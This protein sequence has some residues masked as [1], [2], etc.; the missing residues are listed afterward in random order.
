MNPTNMREQVSKLAP[1]N[2][3]AAAKLARKISDSWF[4]CQSLAYAAR[5]SPDPEKRLKLL[6][7]ALLAVTHTREPNRIVTVSAWPLQVLCEIGEFARVEREIERLIAIIETEPHSTRRNCALF[8]LLIKLQ[9]APD[10]IF[11]RILEVFR[12]TSAVGYGWKRDRNV[13]DIAVLLAIKGRR[14]DAIFMAEL[15]P[16]GRKRRTF[17]IIDKRIADNAATP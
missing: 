16:E 13:R 1:E 14:A 10:I 2:P 17:E 11:N 5:H 4:C 7:E 3:D 15:M 9:R 6:E 8:E 12:Q